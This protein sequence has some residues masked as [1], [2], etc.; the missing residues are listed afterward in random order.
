M[1][2][3]QRFSRVCVRCEQLFRPEGRRGRICDKCSLKHA[4]RRSNVTPYYSRIEMK[5]GG[6]DD[7]L[8]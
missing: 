4:K 6:N 3:K 7:K 1:K 2:T 5:G 8:V